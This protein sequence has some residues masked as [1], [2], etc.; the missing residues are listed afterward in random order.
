M[1]NNKFSIIVFLMAACMPCSSVY[2]P[3]QPVQLLS[4]I[5]AQAKQL[6]AKH[7]RLAKLGAA[8][9]AWQVGNELYNMY[10]RSKR[11]ER[12]QR[13]AFASRETRETK[14]LFAH[15]YGAG[16]GRG[17]AEQYYPDTMD[18]VVAPNFRDG[19]MSCFAQGGDV[20]IYAQAYDRAFVRQQ[21]GAL[22]HGMSRGGAVVLNLLA[23]GGDVD[24][25]F[26]KGAI[27]EVPLV[28]VQD[29]IKRICGQAGRVPGV[30]WTVHKFG[31]GALFPGYRTSGMTG[32]DLVP[33]IPRHIP[34]LIMTHN[35]DRQVPYEGSV[36]LYRALKA[37]GHEHVYLW[38][39]DN[40]TRA[41]PHLDM[42]R[43]YHVATGVTYQQ[44][45]K[46]FKRACHAEPGGLSEAD[47]GILRGCQPRLDELP[48]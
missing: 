39:A 40:P 32:L 4:T 37:A 17:Q 42:L 15:G 16:F 46:A 20:D 5:A 24:L 48:V 41:N 8:F 7:P 11:R 19:L 38:I 29:C 23:Y 18:D 14:I 12:Q 13:G 43:A 36:A 34:I 31:M 25:S 44:V 21:R 30:A 9:V 10:D 1:Y 28:V 45:V 22:L 35:R 27:L 2:A 33:Y 26:V 6:Y 47:E 3:A